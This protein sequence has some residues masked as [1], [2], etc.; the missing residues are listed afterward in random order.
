MLF[1]LYER[2]SM[3]LPQTHLHILDSTH[4][5]LLKQHQVV[6][7]APLDTPEQREHTANHRWRPPCSLYQIHT[8]G[9]LVYRQVSR[10]LAGT[11]RTHHSMRCHS[12]EGTHS[13][14]RWL[15]RSVAKWCSR[16]Q[17]DSCG[18]QLQR[19]PLSRFPVLSAHKQRPQQ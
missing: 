10:C 5:A 15:L 13:W 2:V 7:P 11:V 3:H 18:K 4:T 14:R 16:H 9:R 6:L 19:H 1:K 17:R 12:L 8:A